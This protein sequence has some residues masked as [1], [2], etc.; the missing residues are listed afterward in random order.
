LP[1]EIKDLIVQFPQGSLQFEIGIQTLN[2]TVAQNVSRKN[3]LTKVKDNFTYLKNQKWKGNITIKADS[4]LLV[5][6]VNNRW[7]C[8]VSHL[9]ELRQ[10]IWELLQDL[11]LE[12]TNEQTCELIH[13]RREFNKRPDE[14]CRL[15][16]EEYSSNKKETK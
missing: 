6:Q 9:I 11:S 10:K 13:V 12:L 5:E 8:K 3:D 15:A 14:L 4:K 1:Q 2:P 16:Y 7:K